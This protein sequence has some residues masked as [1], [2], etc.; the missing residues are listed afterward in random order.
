MMEDIRGTIIN[1]Y[2]E[3]AKIKVLAINHEY[4]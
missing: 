2:L 4:C 1:L 3:S